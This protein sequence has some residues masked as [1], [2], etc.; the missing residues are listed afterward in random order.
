MLDRENAVVSAETEIGNDVAPV[1]LAV[2]VA[3]GA[4]YPRAMDLVAVVLGIKNAVLCLVIGVDLGILCVYV[5]DS[6]LKL[7]DSRNGIHTLP[8]KVRGVK[9]C[10]NSITNSRAKLQ[11][12]LGIVNT[13]SGVHLKCNS[14]TVSLAELRGFLPVRN[15]HLV[16]LPLKNGKEILR[17]GTCH[18]VGIFCCSAVTGTA[19]EGNYGVDTELFSKKDRVAEIV[20]IALCDLSIGMYGVS[21]A[22]KRADLNVVLFKR[23]NEF[24]KLFLIGKKLR[25]VAVILSGISSCTDLNGVNAKSCDYFQSLVKRLLTVQISKNT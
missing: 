9:V 21:M 24:V 23:S 12:S 5:V 13:E 11:E 8:D 15:K 17:P 20:V 18:P 4:E 19:G 16:P 25:R 2:A 6:S 3:N 14:Y 7:A 10:A 1:C 22:C